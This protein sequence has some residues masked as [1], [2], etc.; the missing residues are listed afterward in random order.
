MFHR[1]I[2]RPA[3]WGYGPIF[4]CVRSYQEAVDSPRPCAGV[5]RLLGLH[6]TFG[7]DSA[8]YRAYS[9]RSPLVDNAIGTARYRWLERRRLRLGS[10]RSGPPDAQIIRPADFN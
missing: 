3:T 8:L 6:I 4:V 7:L 10:F 5:V 1:P 9:D 2:P